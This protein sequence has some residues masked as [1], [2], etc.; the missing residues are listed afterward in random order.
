[1]ELHRY[2]A[3]SEEMLEEIDLFHLYPS[4]VGRFIKLDTIALVS[5]CELI[6]STKY[7][8]STKQYYACLENKEYKTFVI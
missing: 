5:S 8:Q 4:N 7:E 3:Q 1:M 2:P 6:E